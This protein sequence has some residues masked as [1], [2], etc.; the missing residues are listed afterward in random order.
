MFPQDDVGEDHDED[1]G[2]EDDGGRITDRK[3]SKADEDA[4]HCEAA[5]QAWNR[6][7]QW[8]IVIILFWRKSR[9]LYFP[10]NWNNNR[11]FLQKTDSAR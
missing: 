3:A 7:D 8:S 6:L 9:N 10:I 5:D 2:T 1:R 11:P 4:G